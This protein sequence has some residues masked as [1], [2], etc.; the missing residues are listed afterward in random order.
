MHERVGVAEVRGIWI[1][2]IFRKEQISSDEF[3]E[4]WVSQFFHHKFVFHS[5]FNNNV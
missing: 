4:K 1:R 3:E 5:I 2:M